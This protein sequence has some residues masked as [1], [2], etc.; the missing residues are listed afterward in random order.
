MSK[1]WNLLTPTQV[2]KQIG[3]IRP[4]DLSARGITAIITD[5]DN[6]LVPWRRYNIA[7]DV[8]QW[9]ADLEAAQ[10][11]IVIASNTL[12]TS[13]LQ[14]LAQEMRIPFV[15]RVRKPWV[16][17]FLRAMQL[18]QSS[19]EQTAV[20]G[21]Q[22]FTDVLCGNRLQLHTVLLRPPIAKE[23]FFWTRMLRRIEN[24]LINLLQRKGIW[25]NDRAA[26]DRAYVESQ[27]RETEKV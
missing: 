21:D 7:E 1:F 10:I 11:K 16:G 4:A 18:M 26:G 5:L 9:L 17:G 23:E 25:P 2:V 8:V 13:R 27:D 15:D 22:I 3:D 12:H 19:R 14:K 6:T 24:I 20:V